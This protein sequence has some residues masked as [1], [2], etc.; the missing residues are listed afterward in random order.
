M[1]TNQK[2]GLSLV[3]AALVTFYGCGKEEPKKAEAPKAAAPAEDTVTVKIGHA[4]PLTGGIA[5]LGKDDENGVHLAVDEATARKMKIGGKVVKFEM[6]SEDD[7]ADPKMGPTIAQKFV[8]A[9][10]AGV[11]GH[12][13]SGVSIPASAV[14]NQAGLPMISG[15][16][17]NPKLTEQGFKVV[18]RTVGRDDQQGPAVAAFVANELK[19]KKV[20]IADDATAY[21]E[22][23]ANEVEKTL[24][25]A[26]VQVVAREKTNDKATD[27][28]AILTKM[29]GKN[30][31]VI[32][33]GGMDAT[34]GPM[35]K[36]AR[37][38]GIKAVFAY[39]D[40]AC[41]S[42]MG[43]LAGPASEGM[44]CSQAGIP[45]QMASKDFQDAFKTKYGEV[46]Q[47]APFFYDA[48]KILIAAM[49]TAD[50][51]DPAKYLPKLAEIKFDGATGHIEFDAKGD[52]KDAEMTIFQMKNGNVDPIAIIKAG[53]TT[54]VGVEAPAA[55]AATAAPAA[56]PGAA[57]A[58]APAM[59]PA[60]D[61]PKK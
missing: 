15:S 3:A 51:T 56:V 33:Y 59:A 52:R 60:K 35:L 9:K 29:K 46:K 55:A 17:T 50:S 16:A 48:T 24:K 44:I 53:K 20:A 40:G 54:K 8:D 47:Y 11:V 23:L 2:L 32:F 27:F 43:K 37:E 12:L 36:Q 34:G 39:G 6:M 21:G 4:G 1:N 49:Q 61:A 41:T 57:P 7:Q 45:T 58:A 30:P 42:E 25:A 18:F 5:H 14:Y 13:N 31:D 19:A 38:L 22:G 10:V 28:K 26:G